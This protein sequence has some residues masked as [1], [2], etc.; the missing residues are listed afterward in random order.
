MNVLRGNSVL[1]ATVTLVM[2]AASCSSSD[3]TAPPTVYYG[4][5]VCD[6]CGMIISDERFA[7]AMIVTA[8]GNR[9]KSRLYDDI[10]CLL[11]D[12]TSRDAADVL[13]RWVHDF[14][15][16]EWRDAVTATYVHSTDLHSPMAFGLAAVGDSDEAGRLLEQ[17]PGESLDFQAVQARFEAGELV[18]HWKGE[19]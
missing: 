10:G 15:T 12:D 16:L 13:A 14:R 1:V 17:Y 6:M 2:A 5:D 7:A 18:M 3:P 9:I 11:N 19:T 4:Q 8:D